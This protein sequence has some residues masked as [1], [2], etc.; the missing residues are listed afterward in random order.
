M[1]VISIYAHGHITLKGY[2][3]QYAYNN[4]FIIALYAIGQ[5]MPDRALYSDRDIMPDVLRAYIGEI[6][7]KE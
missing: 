3:F 2:L 6:I 1:P 7:K 5:I 4:I